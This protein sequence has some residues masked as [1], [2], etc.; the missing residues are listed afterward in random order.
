MQLSFTQKKH[1]RKNFGKLVEGLSI[2]N[3]IEVQKNSY[4]EF[5]ES[6]S[7][8]E[9]LSDLS[10]GIDKVFKS[11]FPIEDGND[12]A[13]LEYISYKLEK[14][15]FDVIEC[16]QRSLS[17]SAALKAN[18][19]LVVYDIDV[20]NNTKQILSAKEQEVFIGDLPLMTPSA[21]FI[22][23]GVERV[24]VNQMHRSPGVFFDHD[25]GKTHASGKLLFNCRII[26]GRGSWLDFEFDPKDILYFRIDRK[27]KLPITTILY[28]LGFTKEK[29]IETFYTKDKYTYN[30]ETK[31]WSTNFNPENYKR[32]IKL[33]YDLIDS[34]TN[35]KILAKGEKLNFII[36]KKLQEKGLNSISVSNHQI[37]GKYVANNVKSKSDEMLFNAGFDITEEQLDK[38]L[39][40][41]GEKSINL[42]NIDPIN[43]GPY[44][45]ETL[46]IDKNSNKTDALND[47]YKVLRPGEAPSLEIAQEIFN[48]L[49]FKKERYDLSEVGRVKL[50]SKLNLSTSLKKTILETTDVIEIIKF[51][52][53]L[54]DGKGDVD[55]IDHLGNRRVRSVGELVENQFRIGLLRMERTVK[56]KMSTFLE[57]ESAMPQD[58]INAKPITTSL[59]DFFATSQLSQFMDQTNPLSEITHKRRVSALGP[60]GLTR[61]RAGFE[62]RDVHP[63]HYGRI[64]PIETPEG[65]NI[66]LINSLATYCRVNK[67]GYIESPYKK[68][69]NGKVTSEIKY[70]SAIEEEKYTIAQANSVLK[71]DGSFAEELVACRKNLNFELSSKENI[72][73]IDVSP[74]QLV[75]VAAALIP[76]LEND[77]ANR[78][79]MGSNM[80][81]QAVPLLKPEAPL[82]GT[83][84]ESDVALDSGVT[85]VAKRNGVV[86]KI[87][88]KRIVVKATEVTDLSQSAVDIYNLSKFQR[89][90]QNTC[91][92]QKPLVKV[93]DKIKKG[94]IIADGPATKLGELALGKNVTVAFM[95]WQG[96][97]FED[98][99]LISERCVT[100]DVFTSVHIEEYESMARDTK[101]GAE[102]ITRDIPNVSEESLRNLDESGIVYV[103]AEVKPGDILVGKVTP[104]SETSSSPEE[105]L[106]RSIFGEK[107]TDVRDSSLK[108]PSGS[109]GVVIDVRVF[110]RH[111]IEKDERSIAI[112]RAE[113]ESVQEDKKVEE[114]ILNRNIKLRA[115][116]L[117]NGQAINKQFKDLKPGITLNKNDL[118]NLN[119]KDLWKISLQKQ[120]INTD[121]EKLKNQFENASEDI[122]MRFEDKVTKIQQGD[123]LLPTVMKVVKVFVA[124]KRRLMPGDKMA[125]RHGNKG[126]V[127]KIVPVE[128][129][130]YMENG[131][132]V[133]IVLNPLGVPSRMNVGQILETHLGWSCSELG[134]QIKN[135]LKNFDKEID[136]LKEKLRDI[137][138]NSY[139]EQVISKLSTKEIAE[140]VQNL[141]N[142]IPIATPVFDGASTKDINNMLNLANLPGTGQ[143]HLWNGQ[144]GER[145]DRPVTVGIIYMLKLNHLVEDK[146]HARSTGP[147]SLVTQQ[148]LGGK[149]Q[150]GGQRFG[151]MEVW[152]LEA[153]GASYTLQEILTVKSDDVAGRTKVYETIVKG[154][155]NFESGVPESFNVLVKEIRALGLNIELN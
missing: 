8:K 62:V 37:I 125:G 76:F 91:I 90:N 102:E 9:Q 53:D 10:K 67:F 77:D 86:D 56:E 153:Y 81:R 140:L 31:N 147:Y 24:V 154:N 123:D 93:G 65:P 150:L 21:T 25:K 151:E 7:L 75:S 136:K 113:I 50:N 69:N 6:K 118:E 126:V 43:K 32:P 84:I 88:G 14:P 138:G 121:L 129:M 63:T 28:A 122:K 72:D 117:L 89:S 104:K 59:K 116:D 133:D 54:R 41:E 13:T 12:K 141:S 23:N 26:P 68:V 30:S 99:I 130:P 92:N 74:K 87:D 57:I 131:K 132:P 40:N 64:C 55:D 111:G 82:V 22:T 146:I 145:F 48:N 18:L 139:Y 100:D 142:G 16:K 114:E 135:Y 103:G 124:V 105:K 47:I 79:L 128:D 1:I 97:N 95:P 44:I 94:D 35:K 149:A 115:I 148:P 20:E 39:K 27:K 143:T 60:G 46:K 108:L 134:D 34:K 155:N 36:A 152:A 109:T 66:G 17:Y 120:E 42:V 85:I 96:Y 119:L 5:L 80:M 127:S 3:L 78:A 49:Y 38:F 106:L 33:S 19:R 2:P 4:N 61:E 15:K 52:L 45:L 73:Y 51:M 83:G 11:I 29:I 137:Y 112:E 98:S 144:T 71:N 101:L 70:L 107:A 58:L 110:N